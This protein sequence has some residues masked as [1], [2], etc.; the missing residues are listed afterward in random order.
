MDKSFCIFRYAFYD[1]EYQFNPQVTQH[2][3]MPIS[4]SNSFSKYMLI[5]SSNSNSLRQFYQIYP[6]VNCPKCILMSDICYTS[7]C[8][9]K[10]ISI[11]MLIVSKNISSRQLFQKILMPNRFKSSEPHDKFFAGWGLGDE[12]KTV[13]FELVSRDI[14]HQKQDVVRIK[15]M[16]LL[17]NVVR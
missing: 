7:S 16:Y 14:C 3:I 12:V 1:Y 17:I 11:L 2:F 5:V 15:V 10:H 6:P 13:P 4:S 9:V 8:H